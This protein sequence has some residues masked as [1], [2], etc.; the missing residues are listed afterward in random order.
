MKRIIVGGLVFVLGVAA[1]TVIDSRV[2]QASDAPTICLAGTTL[3]LGM[4]K[5]EVLSKIS[6]EGYECRLLEGLAPLTGDEAF[7]IFRITGGRYVTPG[8]VG[9]AH[10]KLCEVRV[11][12]GDFREAR[13]VDSLERLYNAFNAL[14]PEEGRWYPMSCRRLQGTGPRMTS[15]ILQVV[16]PRTLQSERSVS[17]SIDE[18]NDPSSSS[19]SSYVGILEGLSRRTVPE[20]VTPQ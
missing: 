14:T 18:L 2:V 10:G 6:S 5:D 15:R 11:S 19:V 3:T 17:I 13:A 16:S 9:F 4:P 1:G 7:T 8:S 20:T 12:W